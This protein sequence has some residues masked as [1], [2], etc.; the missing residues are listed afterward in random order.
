M[1]LRVLRGY[2]R[3]RLHSLDVGSEKDI[4]VLSM[5]QCHGSAGRNDSGI[6]HSQKPK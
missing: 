3:V 5:H 6:G 2:L 1:A 4:A